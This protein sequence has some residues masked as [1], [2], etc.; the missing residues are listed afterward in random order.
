MI[1][2]ERRNRICLSR[3][4]AWTVF[5]LRRGT[6]KTERNEPVGNSGAK[7]TRLLAILLPV[8]QRK[9]LGLATQQRDKN[10]YTALNAC[11]IRRRFSLVGLEAKRGRSKRES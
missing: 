8:S 11:S 10:T 4:T 3:D 7:T 9:E 5:N 2:E 6:S 1:S